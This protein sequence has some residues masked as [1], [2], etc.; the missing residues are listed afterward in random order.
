MS[1]LLAF[2]AAR[3]VSADVTRCVQTLEP[4]AEHAGV[5]IE[6]EHPLSEQGYGAHP[7]AADRRFTALLRESGPA[8]FCTQR[9][10]L[11]G[12]IEHACQA[13]GRPVSLAPV[14]KGAMVVL[15]LTTGRRTQLVA[16]DQLPSVPT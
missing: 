15:H 2:G 3:A 14:G 16:I 4:W 13:L 9:G 5:P 12:L 11:P 6:L 7:L 8:V 1:V 10:A